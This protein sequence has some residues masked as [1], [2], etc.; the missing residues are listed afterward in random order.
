[1]F[2][3]IAA[4]AVAALAVGAVRRAARR[5]PP[6]A[7]CAATASGSGGETG[8]GVRFLS[9]VSEPLD[10]EVGCDWK[11]GGEKRGAAPF[12]LEVPGN[13]KVHF[14]FRKRGYI[15]YAM[16]VIADQ[17]QTVQAVLKPAPVATSAVAHVPDKKPRPE[18]RQK[19]RA[20]SAIERR[21]GRRPRRPQV[22]RPYVRI[23]AGLS[24]A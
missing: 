19:E 12:S 9:V 24:S 7:A 17:P 22:D 4:V 8:A 11:D 13:A 23:P 21:R 16:D 5:A 18:K 14:E 15:D 6:G 1:L 20:R 2:A 3:G 10:A